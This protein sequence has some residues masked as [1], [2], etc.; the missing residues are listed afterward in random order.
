MIEQPILHVDATP[1]ENYPLRILQAYRRMCD[2]KWSASSVGVDETNPLIKAL[3]DMQDKRA[4]IL[5]KAITKL[6]GKSLSIS[7][8]ELEARLKSIFLKIMK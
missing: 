7:D 3:N 1:D 2:G 6:R 5:D 4:K 8:E